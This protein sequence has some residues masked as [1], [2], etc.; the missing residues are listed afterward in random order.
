MSS[1]L[2]S[3]SSL[4]GYLKT[5]GSVL[6]KKAIHSLHPL[7]V[8][9][10][11]P[12]PS[13][14]YIP[15]HRIP[16]EAQAHL[17]AASVKM[18]DAQGAGFIIG[19]PGCIA[20]ESMVYDPVARRHRRVDQI[21]E[22]FHV[23]SRS[24]E[25]QAVIGFAHKPVILGPDHLYRIKLSNG[26]SF[27]VT[28]NHRLLTTKGWL[29]VSEVFGLLQASVP[30]LLV[31][32]SALD[33]SGSRPGAV[34]LSHTPPG[35][36][37]HRSQECH[38]CGGPLRSGSDTDPE[39]TQPQGDGDER[40]PGWSHKDGLGNEPERNPVRLGEPRPSMP[41]SQIPS[42]CGP[43]GESESHAS[44]TP[45]GPDA[46]HGQ[47]VLQSPSASCLPRTTP[48]SARPASQSDS[49]EASLATPIGDS[50]SVTNVEYKRTDVYYDFTV[51]YGNYVMEGVVHHNC[52]KTLS[53]AVAIHEH[54]LRSR[55]KGGSNGKYRAIVICPDHLISKWKN[56]IEDTIPGAV[57]H[58]WRPEGDEGTGFTLAKWFDFLSLMVLGRQETKITV[59]DQPQSGVEVASVSHGPGPHFDGYTF[60]DQPYEYGDTTVERSPMSGKVVQKKQRWIKPQGAEWIVVGRDQ[61]KRQSQTSGLG[62]S[63][64]CFDG[65]KREGHPFKLVVADHKPETDEFGDTIKD[66]R[67]L[68]VQR[69]IIEKRITCPR[70]GAIPTKKGVPMTPGQLE[71]KDVCC[72]AMIMDELGSDDGKCNG[73]DRLTGNQIPYEQRNAK[74][75][76]VVSHAGKKWRVRICNEPLYQYTHKPEWW[77]AALLVQRKLSRIA[78]YLVVDECHEQKGED[79][80]QSLAMGKILGS[81]QYC[82]ALTG[83]FIGGYASHLF[84]L[85]MRMAARDMKARNFEWGK[86]MDFVERYGCIDRIVRSEAPV[87]A[88]ESNTKKRGL[89]SKVGKVSVE[90]KCRPGIMPTLFSQIVM[91]SAMFLKLEQFIDDLPDFEERMVAVDLPAHI[92]VAYN[93]LQNTLVAANRDLIAN[94]NMKLMG[95][96]LWTL[97]SYPDHPWGWEPMFR[98][99]KPEDDTHAV[100]WWRMPKVTTRENFVGVATP[101]NFEKDI[102]LPKERAL[103][104]ICKKNQEDGDQTWVYCEMTG[105]RDV[106][107]RLARLMEAEGLR[108]GILK[109]GDVSPRERE[110][111]IQRNGYLYDVMLSHPQLVATGLDLFSL[112]HGNHN[113]N[114]LVFYQTGFNLFRLRQ[115]SRR[116]WRIGQPKD[117][118]VT[119]LY[120]SGTTQATSMALMGRKAQAAQQLEEGSVS[121]EGLAAMGGDAGA[122]AALV[123][124][125]GEHI[126]PA[127]IQ[128]NWSRV[129]SGAKRE[130]KDCTPTSRSRPSPGAALRVPADLYDRERMPA[131]GV[132]S[133]LDH[134]PIQ[135]QIVGETMVKSV[136][137]AKSVD[138]ALADFRLWLASQVPSDKK[139]AVQDEDRIQPPGAPT[140]LDH[141]PINAQGFGETPVKGVENARSPDNALAG[142]RSWLTSQPR[143]DEKP[144]MKVFEPEEEP[145][146]DQAVKDWRCPRCGGDKSS[147]SAGPGGAATRPGTRQTRRGARR[148]N[149]SRSAWET[150]RV[151]NSPRCSTRCKQA[152]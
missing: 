88:V 103:I 84:P 38:P 16:F 5:F 59:G 69:A 47:G 83:T 122:Q 101:Q 79:S 135:V 144:A 98:G 87:E 17:I 118:T 120:Y 28:R 3:I 152:R 126:D 93:E 123:K 48:S 45:C 31:S 77:P 78:R 128:R 129:K 85:M 44:G 124:A 74:D 121:D 131:P 92:Q 13:F 125:L 137:E 110:V 147:P 37:D 34:R 26:R 32:S 7:H 151:T 117:C 104:D 80:E 8:P 73:L 58:C 1:G 70:C 119:Y 67:G 114:H 134:L 14:E 97:L 62:M 148:I 10:R 138:D 71:K 61:I 66:H 39:Q 22:T 29:Y 141:L 42:S 94:G 36:T 81:T 105:K 23:V 106:M 146:R 115:A 136:K 108:V 6:S 140:S 9:G 56:E 60:V 116:G 86:A 11:D 25:G 133:P 50:V 53:A 149:P 33:P 46:S 24:E 41:D 54:A 132:P 139:L 15:D 107:A 63:R 145:E 91:P 75:G 19:E 72:Q 112:T 27:M 142:F 89:K 18:L 130:R 21:K 150:S 4:S 109:S 95:T 57:V 102:V 35:S 40:S 52:G 30:V 2:A 96:M 76:Q 100:G 51:D 82:L 90:R 65:K 143:P 20:G 111:W 99:E 43:E 12:L 64:Q 49:S 68:T 113:F 55:R 127:E